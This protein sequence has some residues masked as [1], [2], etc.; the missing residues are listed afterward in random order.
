MKDGHSFEGILDLKRRLEGL[1]PNGPRPLQSKKAP[2][3]S[4]VKHF[5]D[6]IS[7]LF[8]LTIQKMDLETLLETS[9]NAQ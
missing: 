9:S 7:A 5:I 1:S 6:S 3:E 4:E 8:T 2:K